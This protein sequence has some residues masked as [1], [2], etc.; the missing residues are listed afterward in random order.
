MGGPCFI[1]VVRIEKLFGDV[2]IA[3]QVASAI[4]VKIGEDL[5][6]HADVRFETKRFLSTYLFVSMLRRYGS[7]VR[8]FSMTQRRQLSVDFDAVTRTKREAGARR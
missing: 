3:W 2:R 1:I 7:M 5:R 8:C 6:T 4:L